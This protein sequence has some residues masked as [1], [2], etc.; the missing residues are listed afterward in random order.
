MADPVNGICVYRR[1][2]DGIPRLIAYRLLRT[3]YLVLF[4]ENGLASSCLLSFPELLDLI[5]FKSYL[6]ALSL[7]LRESLEE[8]LKLWKTVLYTYLCENLKS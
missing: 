3:R 2:S 8:T 5:P 1:S 4:Y 7:P 6:T